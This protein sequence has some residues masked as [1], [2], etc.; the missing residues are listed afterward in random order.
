MTNTTATV[1]SMRANVLILSICQAC[2]YTS[3]AVLISSAA[4]VGVSLAPQPIY[5]TVPI[6]LVFLFSMGCAMPASI[7]MK[8]IGRRS[9]FQLGLAISLLGTLL[10]G[11]A[12]VLDSFTYLCVG[13]AIIGAGNSFGSFYRFAAADVASES[14]RSRAISFVL[15]GSVV[16]AFTGPNLA[17]FTKD[18]IAESVFAGSYFALAAVYIFSFVLVSFLKVPPAVKEEENGK[19][20]NL[21]VIA[22]QPAFILAVASATI[23]YGVM[24]LLMTSTPLAMQVRSMGFGETAQVIQWHIFA[25]FAPSFFTGHLIR[26]YGEVNIILAGLIALITAALTTYIFGESFLS[27]CTA[28][29]FLGF[30]WNF[31]FLGGTTLL[32]STYHSNEKA[33]IQG[34]NDFFVFAIVSL[35]AL[36]SGVLHHLL[37][38]YGLTAVALVA[39]SIV[40]VLVFWTRKNLTPAIQPSV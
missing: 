19:V 38:W 35:T 24:N 40:M 25:M 7:L 22:A 28:L 18:L 3:N 32:T 23:G 20:R 5:G 21:R 8:Y 15:A 37:G 17:N 16:A 1:A 29:I 11:Y 39:L 10:S 13:I 4:L 14:Y 2:L 26:K 6:A 33:F 34:F 30:G 36:M 12:V 27:F 9:G 31:T